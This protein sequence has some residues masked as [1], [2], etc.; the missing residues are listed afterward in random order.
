M[1]KA[2]LW[3]S[4]QYKTKIVGLYLGGAPAI[5]VNDFE[6]VK[7]ALYTREWDGKGAPLIGRHRHPD[8]KVFGKDFFELNH[9]KNRL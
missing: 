1:H 7:N 6:T 8:F 3:F 5:I 4:K 2:A 9:I